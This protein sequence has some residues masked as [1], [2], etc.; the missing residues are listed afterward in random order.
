MRTCKTL[1]SYPIMVSSTL[2]CI[3]YGQKTK[4]PNQKAGGAET[5]YVVLGV[6]D[7]KKCS[8]NDAR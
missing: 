8:N 7:Y 5:W 6:K 3:I 1:S 2:V 4:S